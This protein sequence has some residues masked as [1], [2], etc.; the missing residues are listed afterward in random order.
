MYFEEEGVDFERSE[1]L[2][3]RDS[4]GQQRW[5]TLKKVEVGLPSKIEMVF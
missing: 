2:G 3:F 5:K 4:E 1:G